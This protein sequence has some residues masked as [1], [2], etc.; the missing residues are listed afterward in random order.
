MKFYLGSI[1]KFNKKIVRK[2]KMNYRIVMFKDVGYK[3]PR[4]CKNN[5]TCDLTKT[6]KI[7]FIKADKLLK[8]R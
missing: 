7:S 3:E 5:L 6:L 8:K 2:N 4:A 1:C